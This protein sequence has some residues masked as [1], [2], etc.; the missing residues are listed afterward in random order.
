MAE[1]KNSAK[2]SPKSPAENKKEALETALAQI[3]KQFEMDIHLNL[4]VS[5]TIYLP[6]EEIS[7]FRM[8]L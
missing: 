3:E 8:F 2:A 1:K 6:R 5:T 4:D 7:H